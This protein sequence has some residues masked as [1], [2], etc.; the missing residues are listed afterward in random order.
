MR[1][2]KFLEKNMTLTVAIY[3]RKK[4]EEKILTRRKKYDKLISTVGREKKLL[5]TREKDCEKRKKKE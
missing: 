2:R 1:S 3:K 4:E 5:K